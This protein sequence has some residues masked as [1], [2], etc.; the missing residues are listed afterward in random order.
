MINSRQGIGDN[1]IVM[2]LILILILLINGELHTSNDELID[3]H[4]M[5]VH[6][7]INN[8]NLLAH[9]MGQQHMVCRLRYLVMYPA[10]IT[11]YDFVKQEHG[12]HGRKYLQD[13]QIQ[14]RQQRQSPQSEPI[15]QTISRNGMEVRS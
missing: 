9:S 14:Q 4:G 13:M 6:R 10:H 8:I 12:E 15:R 3:Q 11:Q 2:V 7:D 5:V 1:M